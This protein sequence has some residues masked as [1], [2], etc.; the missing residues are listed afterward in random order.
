MEEG[1]SADGD[2]LS[3]HT[4]GQNIIFANTNVLPVKSTEDCNAPSR[5]RWHFIFGEE[6]QSRKA[7]KDVSA[8]SLSQEGW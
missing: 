3:V 8:A 5:R 6:E 7:V 2:E 4:D 1:I